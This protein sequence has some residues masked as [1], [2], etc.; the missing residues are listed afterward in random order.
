MSDVPPQRSYNM[1]RI[2]SRNTTP[3]RV[4]R[5]ELWHRGYRYRLN[6][7]RLPGKPDLVLP[8]YR[9]VIFIN[10]CFWYGHRGCPKYVQ[11]KA[12]AEFWREKIARN[13]AR[14]EI[15]AQ[16]LDTLSWTVI[17]VWECE[18]TKKNREA[19]IDRIQ[20]DLQAAKTKWEGYCARRRESHAFALE[21]SRRHKELLAQVEA[22]LNLPKSLRRYAKMVEREEV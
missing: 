16:R 22:E 20:A 19:T 18:L 8:K 3:E 2:R 21:Q 10:G 6:D 1:S 4:V 13:I 17:T 11:P 14:D 5:Q 9:S 7:K 15:N 12:N